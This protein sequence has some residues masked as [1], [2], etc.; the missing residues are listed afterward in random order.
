MESLNE[1]Y[2]LI[3]IT[4]IYEMMGVYYFYLIYSLI[5]SPI[6]RTSLS[7]STPKFSFT[8]F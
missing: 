7:N 8:V 3:K 1:I 4:P 5:S 2:F 6:I